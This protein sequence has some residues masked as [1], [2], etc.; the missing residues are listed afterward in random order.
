MDRRTL[1]KAGGASLIAISTAA[2]LKPLSAKA[3]DFSGETIE[4]WIPFREGGGSDT[5]A[6]A[7]APALGR[8]LPGE[9]T[10]IVVNN[11]QSGAIGGTNE[12]FSRMEPTGRMI[13]GTSGSVQFPMLLKDPRVRFN[14]ADMTPIFASP[15]GG[16]VYVP[17]SHGVDNLAEDLDKLKQ[18]KL[19]F[20]SQ[21]AT[22]LDLVPALA[23]QML[24]LDVEVIMGFKSRANGRMSTMR[25]ETTIDYQTTPAYLKHIVPLVEEGTMVPLFT[26]GALDANGEIGRDPTLPDLPSFPEVYENVQDRKPSGPAWEAWQAFFLSGYATQKF[27]MLPKETPDDIVQ[28][29]RDAAKKMA[30]DPE[31]IAFIHSELGK[32]DTIVDNVDK[33]MQTEIG[34]AHV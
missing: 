1:L 34:R 6:R 27:L 14:Y 32:Y 8:F 4:W 20:G 31:V 13:F 10:V 26:F 2:V 21:G 24:G 22:S 19:R 15:A 11:A 9:P 23:F 25:G 28:A 17:A 18:Q 5:W 12:F 30:A 33:A 29:Y 16:V 3:A 7:L